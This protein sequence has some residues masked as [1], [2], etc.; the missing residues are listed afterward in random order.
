MERI[1]FERLPEA[2][3]NLTRE[4]QE[5]KQAILKKGEQNSPQRNKQ[6]YNVQETADFLNLAVPTI[7]SKVSR[8]EL[9][10][11]KRGKKL[12]FSSEELSDYLKEGRKGTN[13]EILNNASDLLVKRKGV[14]NG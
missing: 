14:K 13:S 12:Y 10:F 5:L 2:V 6:F 3:T 1:S 4:F 11:I 8:G 7:Y 9:P